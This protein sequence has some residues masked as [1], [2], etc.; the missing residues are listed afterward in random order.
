[1]INSKENIIYQISSEELSFIVRKLFAEAMADF[2]K[3]HRMSNANDEDF[4]TRKEAANFL[5]I[6][7]STLHSRT[8]L[9]IYKSYKD[10][11]CVRYIKQDLIDYLK[12]KQR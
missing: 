2:D 8:K 12:T 4:L 11:D 1:M 9:K 6:S 10:G 5:G 3:S 7:L